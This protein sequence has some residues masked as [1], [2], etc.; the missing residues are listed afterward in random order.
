MS[1]AVGSVA[2]A[3]TVASTICE[4]SVSNVPAT[5]VRHRVIRVQARSVSP[6]A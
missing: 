3:V 2:G 5:R 6:G 4:E 1:A